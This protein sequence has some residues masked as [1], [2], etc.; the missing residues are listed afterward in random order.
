MRSYPTIEKHK[1]IWIW[2]GDKPADPSK[3]PD[4]SVLDNVPEMHATKRDGITIKANYELIVDNLLDLSHTSYLHEGILGNAERSNP[5]SW[6]IRRARTSLSA[7]T[8]PTS[9]RRACSRSSGRTVPAG[10][11]SSPAC[12]GWRRSTLR[13]LTGTCAIG[14]MPESGTGYHAI[15]MLTPETDKTTHYFFTAVRFNVYSTPDDK[16]NAQL[17]EKIA[18]MRRFAFEE[19]D[20]PVIEAQ[21]RIIDTAVDPG[22]SGDPGDR[23]RARSA[24]SA[25]CR[26]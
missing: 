16:L 9:W 24:T 18:T 19:Q 8:R 20:A 25:S 22:R 21:Q 6:S 7:G 15:H 4:F 13:L 26:S 17:Q 5:T 2:M 12:A 3:V 10:S 23:R 1:A 11:T 14:A